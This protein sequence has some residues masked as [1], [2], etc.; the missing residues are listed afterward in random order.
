MTRHVNGENGAYDGDDGG[1]RAWCTCHTDM[2]VDDRDQG[3][4]NPLRVVLEMVC[5]RTFH[6]GR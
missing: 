4:V 3:D 1:N 2:H 6:R 5:T